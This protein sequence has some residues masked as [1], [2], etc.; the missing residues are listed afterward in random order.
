VPFILVFISLGCFLSEF[1][2]EN[3][4]ILMPLSMLGYAF[5]RAGW[6]RAPFAIGL[7]LGGTAEVSLHQSLQLWGAWFFLRPVSLVLI[8]MILALLGYAI[9]RNVRPNAVSLRMEG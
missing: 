4:V 9:Y 2:W 6:P 7:V 1:H 8:V 5:M 3:L